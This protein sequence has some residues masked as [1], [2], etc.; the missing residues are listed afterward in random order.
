MGHHLAN[1]FSD[2]GHRVVFL[3]P[4]GTQV[5]NGYHRRY[6]LWEDRGSAIKQRE[7]ED[8]LAQDE[9]IR[10]ILR[11]ACRRYQFDWIILLHPFYYAVASLD[12]AAELGIPCSAYF[13]GYELRSQL[14]RIDVRRQGSVLRDRQ[15]R[16][17][18]ERTLYTTGMASE[19]LTNSRY[20]RGLLSTLPRKPRVRVTGCG[21]E[22]SLLAR[23][24]SLSQSYEPEQRRA[25]RTAMGLPEET[26]LTFVGRLIPAK[27]ADRLIDMCREDS[28]LSACIIGTGPDEAHLKSICSAAGLQDRIHF[29]GAVE[30]EQKWKL[31]RAS[32]F[33]CLLSEADDASGQVEGFGITLLEGAAAGALP[34]SSG[35]GGMG[36]VVTA[37]HTGLIAP[38][39][40]RSAAK[41][42]VDTAADPLAMTRMIEAARDG[43]AT[44]FNWDS[45]ARELV[46]GLTA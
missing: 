14:D 9:R 4:N 46:E 3:G 8:G 6:L 5:P 40:D 1:A 12:V 11:K 7:G 24:L 17:L 36:D 2:G 21:I 38:G 16:T 28:K 39:D 22:S 41:L 25:R 33:L 32:D 20:T 18:P 30:E 23:E 29:A 15:L 43:L 45:I 35:S 42:L 34:V 37:G 44:K 31:L 13:H 27:R 26:M 10:R 19:V